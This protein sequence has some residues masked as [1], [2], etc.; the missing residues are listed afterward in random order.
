MS[1]SP[2]QRWRR[3]FGWRD[4]SGRDLSRGRRT[5]GGCP[6]KDRCPCRKGSPLTM[7]P[8]VAE[9]PHPLRRSGRHYRRLEEQHRRP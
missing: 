4:A 7:D 6:L 3:K 8:W 1:A 5:G 2:L 9:G